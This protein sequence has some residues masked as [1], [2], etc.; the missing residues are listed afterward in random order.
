MGPKDRSEEQH[1]FWMVDRHSGTREGW[2]ESNTRGRNASC[3][4][5]EEVV[6]SDST[7]ETESG[8]F[9]GNCTISYRR[10]EQ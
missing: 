7:S 8:Q 10:G 1:V 5:L 4:Q 3:G 2:Y 9:R 6:R